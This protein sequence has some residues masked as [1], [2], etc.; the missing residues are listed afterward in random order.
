[1]DG[2]ESDDQSTMKFYKL[3]CIFKFIST[4]YTS[5]LAFQPPQLPR[6]RQGSILELSKY[7]I[8]TAVV[9]LADVQ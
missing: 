3:L 2:T 4:S 7:N 8:L 6:T 5:V 1:M 9:L